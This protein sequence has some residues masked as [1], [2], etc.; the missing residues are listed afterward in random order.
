MAALHST[1]RLRRYTST[2]LPRSLPADHPQND[3]KI[4]ASSPMELLGRSGCP[5]IIERV[6]QEKQNPRR[7]V[8]LA[9]AGH[10][11]FILKDVS[12]CGFKYFQDMYRDLRG[13]PHLRLLQDVIPD[14]SIFVYKYFTDDLMSLTQ[15]DLPIS[16]TKRILKDALR[17]LGAL[18]DR[19]IVHTDIKANN[20][21]IEWKENDA[22]MVIEEVQLADIESSAYVPPNSDIVGVQAGNKM[23][24]S[25]E[26]HAQG[27]VNKPS[28]VF[29]F[30][31]VCIYAVLKSVLFAVDEDQLAEGIEPLSVVLERQISY[32][33]DQDGLNGLLEHLGDSP[34]REIFEVIRDGFNKTNPRKPFCLLT[35]VDADFKDLIGGLTNFDPAKRLTV[36][37]ALAHRW[38]KDN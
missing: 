6:L 28:D 31:V 35:D 11:K 17:G 12:Q 3:I 25:P 15:K 20:I 2:T 9:T 16:H 5:Y 36:H 27:R 21:L 14:Q 32:F 30:G 33:A 34:W 13:C 4:M 8:Y 29:S 22:G 19:N 1:V 38:F 26:A 18:H 24:R 7:R 10:K 23:W 37:E